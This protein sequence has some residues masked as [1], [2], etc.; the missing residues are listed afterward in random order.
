MSKLIAGV[1]QKE[2][3]C[4]NDACMTTLGFAR[5][6]SGIVTIWCRKC[7]SWNTWRVNYGKRLENFETLQ[8]VFTTEGGEE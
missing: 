6:K 3:N 4:K 7:K 2:L 5:L 1:L 8:E